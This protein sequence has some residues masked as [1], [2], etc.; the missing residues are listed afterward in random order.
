MSVI[1]LKTDQFEETI[2]N[3]DI[4]IF[5]FWA[6]WCG[7][8]KQFGPVF[9]EISE[10]YPDIAFCK[11]NV[12]EEEQLA[13]MFQVRSIPTLVFMREKVV[14]FANPGAIPGSAL[15]EGIEQVLKLDMDQ[16]HQE[17]AKAQAEAQQNG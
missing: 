16:V 17:V 1:N 5:D 9:E 3:N 4:V 12:E 6:E 2:A 13:G 15:E 7:P 10:K 14:V 11:V 8:C